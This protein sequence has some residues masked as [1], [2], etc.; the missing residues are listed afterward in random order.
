MDVVKV[1]YSVIL[2][3]VGLFIFIAPMIQKGDERKRFIYSKAQSYAFMVVIGMLLLEVA[4]SIFLTT[5]GNNSDKGFGIS[6]IMFLTVISV[7]YL[8][9]LLIY[10]KKYGD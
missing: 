3:V 1:V 9:T 2:L 10:R 6:P 5:Q 8:V 7:I 4:K